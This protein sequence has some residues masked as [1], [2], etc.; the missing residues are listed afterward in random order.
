MEI[1]VADVR[2]VDSFGLQAIRSNP[3]AIDPNRLIF[4]TPAL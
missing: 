3:F 4:L 1:I 2:Q